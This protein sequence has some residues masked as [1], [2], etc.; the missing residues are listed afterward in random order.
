MIVLYHAHA[1]EYVLMR[2]EYHLCKKSITPAVKI[3]DPREDHTLATC[4]VCPGYPQEIM[5]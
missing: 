5:F 2:G 1:H 3:I 4:V